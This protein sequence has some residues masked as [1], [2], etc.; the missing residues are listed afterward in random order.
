MKKFIKIAFVSLVLAI[1]GIVGVT[2]YQ[3]NTFEPRPIDHEPVE[4]NQ[5]FFQ[6]SYE[7]CRSRFR[8]AA[9][10]CEGN[11]EGVLIS[12]ISI[13]ST[14]DAG[15]S[16]DW[17]YIP[18]PNS[19]ERLLILTSGIHGIEGYAGSAVQQM[20][21]Q[22]L[23]KH[24]AVD[25]IGVLLVHGVNPYGFKHKRRVTENNV[26]L[27]RNGSVDGSLYDSINS[28]YNDL[29]SMLNPTGE[30]DLTGLEHFFFHFIAVQKILEYSM[31]TLRQAI[32][33]GQYQH[34]RG[35]YFG[36]K[37]LE[38]P[39]T[40][41]T[42]VIQKIAQPYDT[43]FHIDLHTGYGSNGTMHLLALPSKDGLKKKR[44]E[45]LFSGMSIDWGDDPD[46]YTVTGD[47]LEY[48]REIL[49]GKY[50]LPMAFEFG[51]MD[52]QT[53][54]G[55]IRALHNVILENQG[56]H[57]GFQDAKDEAQ[58]RERYT[59]GYYPS[60]EVWRSKAISDARQALGHVIEI[61]ARMDL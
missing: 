23:A 30:V 58:V 7:D 35:V 44:L 18:A 38:P 45:T 10:K 24:S 31:A 15:L 22:D 36:G 21:L 2:T 4:D 13:E 60:S 6:E 57:Y 43:V 25:G 20:F 52:T 49:P 8:A 53:T 46:F 5:A 37:A 27:N 41:L 47:F 40:A 61:Y 59:E 14:K 54:M 50:Y 12:K 3:F 33:Q 1:L 17:C 28:G 9:Q 48:T 11:A 51:T 34:E 55:S 39:L 42:P 32:L 19:S 29:N 56:A 16:I 26:D